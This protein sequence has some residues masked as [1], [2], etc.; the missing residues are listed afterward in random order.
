M[1]RVV[2]GL[3]LVEADST[4]VTMRADLVNRPNPSC[5]QLTK[6]SAR[7]LAFRASSV[8]FPI[9]SPVHQLVAYEK[10]KCV[11]T[12]KVFSFLTANK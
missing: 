7:P 1:A 11:N 5:E 3:E 10:Y 9:E 4:R 6:F 8:V 2:E 12:I